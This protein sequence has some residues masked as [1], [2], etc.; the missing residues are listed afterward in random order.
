MK[1]KIIMKTEQYSALEN[2]VSSILEYYFDEN[3]KHTTIEHFIMENLTPRELGI[4]ETINTHTNK[5]E[6]TM[7]I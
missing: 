4:L 3:L 5:R 6:I 1:I 2:L 7:E